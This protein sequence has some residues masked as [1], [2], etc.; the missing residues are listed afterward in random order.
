MAQ[1]KFE[2]S[3]NRLEKIVTKLETGDLPLEEA[4]KILE[5][6]VRLSKNCLKMLD[7]AERKV[8]ILVKDKKGKKPTKRLE[9]DEIENELEN[10]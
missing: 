1:A 9:F 3:L 4:I 7:E 8:E 5:E 6:G 2:N 10:D